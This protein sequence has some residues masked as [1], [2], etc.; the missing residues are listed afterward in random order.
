MNFFALF[1]QKL[2]PSCELIGTF[3]PDILGR[4]HSENGCCW[5]FLGHSIMHYSWISYLQGGR[6]VLASC[7]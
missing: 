6:M 1:L 3:S 7:W 4:L 2:E 5:C